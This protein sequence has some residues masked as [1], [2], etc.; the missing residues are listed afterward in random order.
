M[1]DFAHVNPIQHNQDI[2]GPDGHLVGTTHGNTF[3]GQDIHGADGHLVG[4]THGNIFGGHGTDN[5]ST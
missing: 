2:Y 3:G 1:H 5:S 4:T